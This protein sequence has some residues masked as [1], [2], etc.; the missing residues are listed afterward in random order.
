[1]CSSVI[2]L[3]TSPTRSGAGHIRHVTNVVHTL[4]SSHNATFRINSI[5]GRR[6]STRSTK[7]QLHE[8]V[9]DFQRR[10]NATSSTDRFGLS[11]IGVRPMPISQSNRLDARQFDMPPVFSA[12]AS[13]L[14]SSLRQRSLDS[15]RQEGVATSPAK[16]DRT[17]LLSSESEKKTG[18]PEAQ[19][20]AA[21]HLQSGEV[22]AA[23]S[24]RWMV[25][26]RSPTVALH[27]LM[28]FFPCRLL[29]GFLSPA[30]N[31]RLVA[32]FEQFWH[33][34]AVRVG[35]HEGLHGSL[36]GP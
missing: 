16:R 15:A 5:A 18:S 22:E 33:D 19:F 12:N 25:D 17:E 13:K 21:S 32:P 14:K 29:S 34:R 31:G 23:V 10:R 4:V 11:A 35:H 2:G 28:H 3:L 26:L 6:K 27:P 7:R 24:L 8:F 30:R 20:S 36:V 9:V 1:M